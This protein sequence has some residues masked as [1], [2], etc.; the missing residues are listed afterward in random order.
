MIKDKEYLATLSQKPTR[1]TDFK[2]GDKV[3]FTNDNGVVFTGLKIIGFSTAPFNG[4][5]IHIDTDC[6]W[7]PKRPDQLTL[8]Q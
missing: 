7:M 3:T 4:R 8:E 6:Y 5:F 1:A 2:V